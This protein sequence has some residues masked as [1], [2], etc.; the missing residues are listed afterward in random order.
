MNKN[1]IKKLIKCVVENKFVSAKKHLDR[2]VIDNTRERIKQ[3]Y[4]TQLSKQN[5]K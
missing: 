4:N 5:S 3:E 1:I 2:L